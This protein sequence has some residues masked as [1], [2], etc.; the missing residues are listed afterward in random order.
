VETITIT[1]AHLMVGALSDSDSMTSKIF[2]RG[3]YLL[4]RY[5]AS[6]PT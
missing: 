5:I 4:K 3:S 6:K 2:L 1:A